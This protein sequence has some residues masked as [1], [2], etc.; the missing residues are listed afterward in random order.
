MARFST[1][2]GADLAA[3]LHGLGEEMEDG[4]SGDTS[5]R[6]GGLRTP[7]LW[8]SSFL[9]NQGQG[10]LEGGTA[11]MDLCKTPGC[12]SLPPR[13]VTGEKQG[14][15]WLPPAL[16]LLKSCQWSCVEILQ[17]ADSLK[18]SRTEKR[19]QRG[20]D[21]GDQDTAAR[22]WLVPEAGLSCH[23]RQLT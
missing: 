21:E 3:G 12:P 10:G 6:R 9:L 1:C 7:P 11:A 18:G 19:F 20:R 17:T 13:G 22:Q 4:G 5:A 16:T 23:T 15:K 2:L 14:K 8:A